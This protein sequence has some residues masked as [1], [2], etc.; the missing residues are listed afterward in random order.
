MGN[1]VNI[2]T[3]IKKLS[4]FS[5]PKILQFIYNFEGVFG[6]YATLH[7]AECYFTGFLSDVPYKNWDMRAEYMEGTNA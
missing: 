5:M 7:S 3:L 2:N 4:P 6:N 1:W